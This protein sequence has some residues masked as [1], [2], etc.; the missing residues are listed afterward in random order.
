MSIVSCPHCG[1]P[2]KGDLQLAGRVVACPGC[3]RRFTM[4]VA[5][6]P[7]PSP[8]VVIPPAPLRSVSRRQPPPEYKSRIIAW[9]ITL[10]I[11]LV[12][13]V[14]LIIALAVNSANRDGQATKAA[15][16]KRSA[17]STGGGSERPLS[18]S[19]QLPEFNQLVGR[20]FSAKHP[21]AEARMAEAKRR[22]LSVIQSSKQVTISDAQVANNTGSE[23]GGFQYGLK[24]DKDGT[25]MLTTA[26]GQEPLRPPGSV[27]AD[28]AAVREFLK[29]H[30]G[31]D[32]L[33]IE[34]LTPQ[35][36][37]VAHIA[38]EGGK[39]LNSSL[40]YGRTRE[41]IQ[42]NVDEAAEAI[43]AGLSIEKLERIGSVVRS[44]YRFDART[45]S[46][47]SNDEFLV[48]NG[49]V[50]T[51]FRSEINTMPLGD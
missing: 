14:G 5:Q 17:G 22:G 25:L 9:A 28:Q 15:V 30:H 46:V 32:N 6:L 2:I 34:Q 48:L 51:R 33:K 43:N 21:D 24:M 29:R 41:E 12:A 18:D 45:Y 4:P 50:V 13:G 20:P 7:L 35:P 23:I 47:R 31:A 49:K 40:F 10:A 8:P 36:Y 37:Y 3:Q 11:V 42:K 26:S 1:Q 44:V 38:A 39:K 16:G 19:E 27:A